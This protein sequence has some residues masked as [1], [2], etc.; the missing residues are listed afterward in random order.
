MSICLIFFVNSIKY[1]MRNFDIIILSGGEGKRLKEITDVPKLFIKF[2]NKSFLEILIDKFLLKNINKIYITSGYKKEIFINEYSKIKRELI[3]DVEI[4]EEKIPLDT[5]GAIKNVLKKKDLLDDILVIYG[6]T[7]FNF[8]ISNF[9]NKYF[10]L[11]P[12]I[13]LSLS[14]K[15]FSKRY[16]N[17]YYKNDQFLKTIK[18][19]KFRFYSNVFNGLAMIKRNS[20]SSHP[21]DKFSFDT[22]F[23]NYNTKKL[24]ILVDKINSSNAFID[25][26]TAKSYKKMKKL[27]F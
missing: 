3:K 4:V 17:I 18:D 15:F 20:I 24:K 5:G 10:F 26:G 25:F 2:Q 1:C 6:D 23:L 22:D 19:N 9:I 27:K 12:D 14:I 13:L 11:N 16:G 7:Y 8:N 21:F